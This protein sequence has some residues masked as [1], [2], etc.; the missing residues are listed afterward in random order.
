[1][2]GNAPDRAERACHRRCAAW[3]CPAAA[4]HREPRRSARS[5]APA[6]SRAADRDWAAAG[7]CRTARASRAAGA[8]APCCVL[9]H[10]E[11]AHARRIVD[12]PLAER[13]GQAQRL[14]AFP[15]FERGRDMEDA[16]AGI[17]RRASVEHALRAAGQRIALARIGER[18]IIGRIEMVGLL[19]PGAHRLPEADIE[20]HQ[21]P[22]DMRVGA[23]EHPARRSRRR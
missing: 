8:P 21:A 7:N 18:K 13:V 12:V 19:A 2:A 11:G 1:M 20:R 17:G 23:V 4:R 3:R 16:R 10:D 14:A 9:R 5:E 6:S 15:H 22:A